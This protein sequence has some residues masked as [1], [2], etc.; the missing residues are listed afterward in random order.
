MYKKRKVTENDLKLC[1]SIFEDFY[2]ENAII[3]FK[4]ANWKRVTIEN[5]YLL[6]EHNIIPFFNLLQV[7]KT[8][9][10]IIMPIMHEKD[11]QTKNIGKYSCIEFLGVP[12]K[13]EFLFI[14]D[15]EN[16]TY[17]GGI[18]ISLCNKIAAFSDV[19]NSILY[20]GFEKTIEREFIKEFHADPS[21]DKA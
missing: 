9:G 7:S 13:E 19:D 21:M 10:M 16:F 14:S 6:E 1:D 4:K 12:K 15:E 18:I 8:P 5:R 17:T 20:L 2:V 11:Y 3:D